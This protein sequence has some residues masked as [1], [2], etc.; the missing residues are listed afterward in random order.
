MITERAS[1]SL[2]TTARREAARRMLYSKFY[3]GGLLEGEYEV[4]SI[5]EG[6][7]EEAEGGE[8]KKKRKRKREEGEGGGDYQKKKRKKRKTEKEKD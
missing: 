8:R 1:E 4:T 6:V 3:R 5:N 2:L 7:G